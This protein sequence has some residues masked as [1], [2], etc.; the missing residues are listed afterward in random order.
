[1]SSKS[2]PGR[3]ARRSRIP[4]IFGVLNLVFGS[5]MLLVGAGYVVWF[6]MAPSF[7]Q[8]IQVNV[9]QQQSAAKAKRDAD[10]A[11]YKAKEAAAKTEEEKQEWKDLRTTLESTTP[12]VIVKMDDLSG[13]DVMADHRL[14][15]FYW[16][17]VT[18]GI[19]LNLLMIIAGAGLVALADWSRRLALGVA[20]A[21]VVRWVA[22]LVFTLTLIIPITSERMHAAFSKPE[23]Q[24]SGPG[25]PFSATQ[26]VQYM[27]IFSAVTAVFSA[28]LAVIYPSLS[29][30][31]LTRPEARAA[32]LRR[33]EPPLP[34]GT[35]FE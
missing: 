20:G 23:V 6:V 10:I 3:V 9:Q 35:F 32:C 25:A 28:I 31:F 16:T 18:S 7:T 1:M 21:K 13:W 34:E 5:I 4:R 30:W 17:E 2:E 27:A 22:I 19:L 12:P 14:A 15:I 8:Q 29:I 24:A 26:I 11:E 33:M